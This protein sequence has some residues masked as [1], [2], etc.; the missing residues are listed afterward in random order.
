ML[1]FFQKNEVCILKKQDQNG[2]LRLKQDQNK[3][4]IFYKI[5]VITPILYVNFKKLYFLIFNL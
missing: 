3:T 1:I 5:W 2:D 4:Q